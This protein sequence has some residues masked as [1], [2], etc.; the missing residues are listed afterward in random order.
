MLTSI[1]FSGSISPMSNLDGAAQ[2]HLLSYQGKTYIVK[3]GEGIELKPKIPEQG[4]YQHTP[5]SEHVGCKVFEALGIPVQNTLL[6]TYK[7]REVVACESFTA[8]FKGKAELVPFSHIENAILPASQRHAAP[9]LETMTYVFENAPQ[10]ARIRDEAMTRY[11][12]TFVVDAIIA[13][14]DRHGGNWG[15]IAMRDEETGNLLIPEKL[16]PVY[17]CGSAMAARMSEESMPSITDNPEKLR[18]RALGWPKPALAVNGERVHFHELLLAP[19]GA[20]ARAA[21][22]RLSD[23]IDALDMERIVNNVP[24]ISDVRRE[25]YVAT[26]NSRIKH[27]LEPCRELAERERDARFERELSDIEGFGTDAQYGSP[28]DNLGKR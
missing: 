21:Y 13:N 16:A 15:Y 25:F 24:G 12:D 19:Q 1:D 7:G 14:P 28:S 18:S 11:W 22:L 10:L 20:D 6:G 27:I 4:S 5:M 3:Y 8:P 2:K 17:D 26:V 23:K 9:H